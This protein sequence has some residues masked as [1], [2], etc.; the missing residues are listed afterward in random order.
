MSEQLKINEDINKHTEDPEERTWMINSWL[1]WS[2][3]Q[4]VIENPDF[5]SLSSLCG[6]FKDDT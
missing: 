3:R 4:R 2:N 6:T 5:P 1:R